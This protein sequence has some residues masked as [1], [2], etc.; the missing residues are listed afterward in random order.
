MIQRIFSIARLGVLQMLR[1]RLYLSLLAAGLMLVATAFVLDR[2]H[3]SGE[4]RGFV[5]LGLAFCSLVIVV[6]VAT[7]G[8]TMVAR[9]IETGQIHLIVGRPIG[10]I[11]FVLGRF[12]SLAVLVVVSNL[13]LGVALAVVYLAV[14]GVAPFKLLAAAVFVSLEGCIMASVVLAFSVGSSTTISTVFVIALF[15]LGRITP[16]FSRLLESDRF[17]N[18][19]PIML[20]V[21]YALPHLDRFDLTGWVIG[22]ANP[23]PGELFGSAAYAMLYMAGMLCIAGFR[24]ERRDLL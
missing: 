12:F 19:E 23:S 22:A 16:V 14:G 10:R 9:E 21:H 2:L 13:C 1:S 17:G 7:T 11:E 24:F 15:I 6:L 4:G 3:P 8:I 5:G 20:A 18:V